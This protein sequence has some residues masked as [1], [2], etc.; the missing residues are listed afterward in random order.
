MRA[1]LAELKRRDEERVAAALREAAAAAGSPEIAP[2]AV[3]ALFE[4]LSFQELLDD[5]DVCATVET[6]LLALSKEHDLAL[7]EGGRYPGLYR[8]L[9]HSSPELRSLVSRMAT[10]AF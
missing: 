10:D 7:T 9:A 8:L 4:V 5:A 1:A 6:A 3:S 2:E